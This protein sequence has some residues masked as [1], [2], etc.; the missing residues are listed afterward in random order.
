MLEPRCIY[1]VVHQD[2]DRVVLRDMDQPGRPSLT[3]D[4]EQVVGKLL[5]DGTIVVG[6]T[7]LFYFDSDNQYDELVFSARGFVR[8][9]PASPADRRLHP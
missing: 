3:N 4:A 5:R 9:A 6:Q 1:E 8:F 7:R 2:A